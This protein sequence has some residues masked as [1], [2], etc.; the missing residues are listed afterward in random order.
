MCD[1]RTMGGTQEALDL[2]I[3]VELPVV[4]GEAPERER[5]KH[6][7]RL[8]PYLGKFVPQPVETLLPRY[9]PAGGRSSTRSQ[10]A[11]DARPVARDRVRRA[12]VDIAAFN[13]SADRGED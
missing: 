7:H 11:D 6:V 12:G 8:H 9:V 13:C 4:G 2:E 5:T 3:G 1:P 10:V